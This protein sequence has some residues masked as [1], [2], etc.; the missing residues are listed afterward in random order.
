MT[1]QHSGE[2]ADAFETPGTCRHIHSIARAGF[3]TGQTEMTAFFSGKADQP[4]EVLQIEHLSLAFAEDMD[5]A[6]PRNPE[7][8]HAGDLTSS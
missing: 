5:P 2:A 8:G 4:A 7:P 6:G 1:S 3:F